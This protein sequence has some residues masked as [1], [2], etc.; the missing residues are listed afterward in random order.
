MH[1]NTLLNSSYNDKYLGQKFERKSKP[2]NSAV[3][4]IMWKTFGSTGEVTGDN[5]AHARC[6]MGN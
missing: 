5:M 1:I 3:Y 4:E 2:E 6:M